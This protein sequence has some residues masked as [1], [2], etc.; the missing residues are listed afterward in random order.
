[1][2]R[3]QFKAWCTRGLRALE[4]KRLAQR[5]SR[6]TDASKI[7]VRRNWWAERGSQ[8]YINNESGL[9]AAIRYVRDGQDGPRFGRHRR[10]D[11]H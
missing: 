1:V 5:A 10:D 2:I 8:R 7:V 3:R 4:R 6:G 9:E 11:R